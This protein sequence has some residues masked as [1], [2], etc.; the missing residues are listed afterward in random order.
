MNANTRIVVAQ[1]SSA[2]DLNFQVPT[3]V[4]RVFDQCDAGLVPV[5]FNRQAQSNK[6]SLENP[7]HGQVWAEVDNPL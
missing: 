2:S 5:A 4:H 3:A 6:F 1:A 7:P